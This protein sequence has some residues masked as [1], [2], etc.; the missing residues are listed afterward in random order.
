MEPTPAWFFSVLQTSCKPVSESQPWTSPAYQRITL[1]ETDS[2]NREALD[3][4]RKNPCPVR[5]LAGTQRAGRG[6]RGRQWLSPIGGLYLSL[7]LRLPVGAVALSALPLMAAVEVAE[8]LDHCGVI[9]IGIKWPND[10]VTPQGKLGGILVE[11][12]PAC[13]GE[14]AIAIGCGLNLSPV[15]PDIRAQIDQPAA[16]LHGWAE[17]DRVQLADELAGAW[18]QWVNKNACAVDPNLWRRWARWDV[19]YRRDVIVDRDGCK[20]TGYA[21]GI[22]EQGRLRVVDQEGAFIID[23]GEVTVRRSVGS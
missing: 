15:A 6:R 2:T 12:V 13:A 14:L 1:L 9:G 19:L 8:R 22:D 5:V 17:G 7:G 3:Q 18:L 10:L 20:Y 4:V 11:A 21:D 23:A 16:N